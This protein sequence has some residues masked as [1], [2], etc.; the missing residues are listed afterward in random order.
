MKER[1]EPK[2][3]ALNMETFHDNAVFI[4]KQASTLGHFVALYKNSFKDIQILQLKLSKRF[5]S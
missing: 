1:H 2:W 5:R 4:F 3:K